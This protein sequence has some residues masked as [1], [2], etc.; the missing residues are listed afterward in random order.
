MF[1]I[2]LQ[3]YNEIKGKI[4]QK[5]YNEIKERI[6]KNQNN[7]NNI[8]Q[9][10]NKYNEYFDKLINVHRILSLKYG[11][12]LDEYPEQIMT[13]KYLTGNEK[14]LE[15]GGNIG[16]NS[17][18]IAYI[19]NKNNNNNLVTL[20]SDTYISNQL[21]ENK[22]LNNLNFYIENAALSN[23]KL[24]QKDWDTIPSDI[25]LNGYKWINTITLHELNKKY[26]IK[27]D[28]LV[29][30][31][32]GA[33]YYILM[34]TPEI[35]NNINLIIMENDY[36]DISHKNYVDNNLK[37]NNFYVDYFESGGH[38]GPCYNNFYEVWK[39]KI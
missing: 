19:L 17:L 39:K 16:R 28:T 37:I 5:K 18:I 32:E 20:E 6:E 4:K 34:D 14:V 21:L 11:S 23:R 30:D 12:F 24:I 33:F 36:K 15:I 27:F 26:N 8:L 13:I 31:C 35:L 3:K 38:R 7:V 2:S 1:K 22:Q 29:I 10:K 9:L 25:L